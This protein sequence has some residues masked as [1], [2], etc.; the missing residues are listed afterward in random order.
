MFLNFK[1]T[2]QPA[3]FFVVGTPIGNLQDITLRALEILRSVDIIF[4]EDTRRSIKLLNHFEIKKTLKSCPYFKERAGAVEIIRALS[5]GKSVAYI[6]DAGMPAL[7]DPGALLV[8]DIRKAG[9]T[10]EIIG[11][12][13][14]LSHFLAGIGEELSH[15][16]F[17]GFLPPR[18]KDRQELIQKNWDY[19]VIFFESP[20]RIGSTLELLVAQRPGWRL[21]LGKELSKISEK[22]FSGSPEEVMKKLGSTKGE[23]IGCW[24]PSKTNG[25]EKNVDT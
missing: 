20:H 18:L 11:G 13:S 21:H 12:V 15:F 16:I 25:G 4:C 1:M 22:F 24:V 10:V 3:H 5:D 19:P 14:A 23:W 9:F 17:Y 7:S 8:G 2:I 6:S